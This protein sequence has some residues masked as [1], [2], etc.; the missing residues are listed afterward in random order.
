MTTLSNLNIV[1]QHGDSAR[2]AQNIRNQAVESSQQTAV[3][4]EKQAEQEKNVQEPD[5]SE[6]V[7]ADGEGTGNKK[8][9]TKKKK[10]KK[11]E[12][13]KEQPKDGTGSLL[14]TVA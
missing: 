2:E 3:Q 8:H 1:V 13:A 11:K 10:K 7:K 14:D 12:D 6:E 5:H 9:G 4:Q